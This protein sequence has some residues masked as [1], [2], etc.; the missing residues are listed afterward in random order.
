MM[1]SRR[2]KQLKLALALE[3]RLPAQPHAAIFPPDFY[4]DRYCQAARRAD[5][6]LQKNWPAALPFAL[7]ELERIGE[8]LVQQLRAVTDPAKVPLARRPRA[9][10][11][12]ILMDLEALEDEFSEVGWDLREKTLSVVTEPVVLKG[13]ELGRFQIVLEYRNLGLTGPYRVIALDPNP[14]A[15]DST[16][17]HPHVRD[18]DL[19]EGEGRS[20]IQKALRQGRF[21]D[22]FV[23]IN[24]V[25]HTYNGDS[26][27]VP[28]SRWEGQSCSDCG[29]VVSDDDTVSC[30]QC[31]SE[32]C[33]ECSSSCSKCYRSLCAGCQDRCGTCSD[34]FCR[35][36]LSSCPGCSDD[37]CASCLESG[38][39]EDCQEV[40]ADEEQETED[41][42]VPAEAQ[43]Q[44]VCLGQ[45]AVPPG[46]GAD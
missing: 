33:C 29:T 19:C 25:L 15:G 1:T 44:S 2:R 41:D 38:R 28:L 26:A 4:W 21:Y 36:C 13:I 30:E 16:T 27:Y 9:S 7:E 37:Y 8:S 46:P 32:C 43:V 17:T 12:E 39:C 5:Y 35:D 42:E 24:Q 6:V 20:P 11:R 31:H 22:F 3:R 14:A 45:A 18:E 10:I 23:L 40:D 34:T